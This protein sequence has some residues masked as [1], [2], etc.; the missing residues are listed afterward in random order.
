MKP[1]YFSTIHRS[2]NVPYSGII[3]AS[4]ST[5]AERLAHRDHR[6]EN[7]T[8]PLEELEELDL[9]AVDIAL[10]LDPLETGLFVF[11]PINLPGDGHPA[12]FET[13]YA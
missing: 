6:L 3:C 2:D 7:F 10:G 4:D 12:N 5:S 11:G 1:F 9:R 8:F 13:P